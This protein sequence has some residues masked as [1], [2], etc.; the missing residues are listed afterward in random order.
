[1]LY[2]G[3]IEPGHATCSNSQHCMGCKNRNQDRHT[4]PSTRQE[5]TSGWFEYIFIFGLFYSNN[6]KANKAK[7]FFCQHILFF[8]SCIL[9]LLSTLPK[10]SLEHQGIPGIFVGRSKEIQSF[11][12]KIYENPRVSLEISGTFGKCSLYRAVN[13]KSQNTYLLNSLLD[14]TMLH[15]RIPFPKFLYESFFHR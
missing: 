15:G 5:N 2:T 14:T 4:H 12:R 10:W 11:P 3:E 7:T 1:M 6:L 8:L 13:D 9:T